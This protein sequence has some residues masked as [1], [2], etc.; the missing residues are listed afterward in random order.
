MIIKDTV[1][2]HPLS[3]KDVPFIYKTIDEERGYLR[4]WLPFVDATTDISVIQTYVE[5]VLKEEQIQFSIYIGDEFVGLVGFNN[6]D[7]LNLKIEIGYWI[8]EKYQKIGIVTNSV[9]ILLKIAFED[10]GMKSV[11]IKVAT[12]NIKS[13]KIPEKLR[14]KWEGTERAGELLVDDKFTDLEIYSMLREEFEELKN[15]KCY[16]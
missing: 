7:N 14:F 8:S 15:E 4:E 5:N 6:G 10:L 9:K 2:L 3:E 1:R 11:R 13:R 16:Q 12:G